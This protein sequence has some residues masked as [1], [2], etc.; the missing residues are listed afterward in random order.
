MG[1]VRRRYLSRLARWSWLWLAPGWRWPSSAGQSTPACCLLPLPTGCSGH[2]LTKQHLAHTN[3]Q[4]TGM[5]GAINHLTSA[6]THFLPSHSHRSSSPLTP[7]PLFYSWPSSYVPSFPLLA[8][9]PHITG[10]SSLRHTHSHFTL[11]ALTSSRPSDLQRQGCWHSGRSWPAWRERWPRRWS[12][13]TRPAP[14]AN[15][16]AAAESCWWSRCRQESPATLPQCWRRS[17]GPGTC[18]S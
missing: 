2:Q 8:S 5:P 18:R 16:T 4:S 7:F 3:T 13:G 14:A 17:H 9:V 6:H 15:R 11:P 12:A 1:H 10:F